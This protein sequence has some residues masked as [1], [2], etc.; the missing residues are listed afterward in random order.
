MLV[1]KSH[2]IESNEENTVS[3]IWYFNLLKS[4]NC[5]IKQYKTLASKRN[6]FQ[7]SYQ[8]FHDVSIYTVNIR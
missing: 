7:N 5:K 3:L 6:Y 1:L 4:I 8:R 2:E